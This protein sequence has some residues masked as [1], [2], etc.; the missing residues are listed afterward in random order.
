MNR[1]PF[2]HC[3]RIV[4]LS[5]TAAFSQISVTFPTNR[6]V[7]QR[8]NNNEATL[9]IGGYM[10]ESFS[11]IEARVVPLVAGEGQPSPV[12]GGWSTLQTAP[13]GGNFYGSITVKGGWYRLEVQGIRSGQSPKLA[14]V[15]R[16]GVGEVFLVAG[17]SNATGGDGRPNGPGA[18]HDQVNSV[19]FQNYVLSRNPQTLPYS[20]I[21]LPC[22]EFV[23]LDAEVKTAPFGNYAWCWGAF[24]D[25]I[26]EKLKVPV[27]IFNAGWSSTEIKNW[28]ETTNPTSNTFSAY[29][30]PFPQGLPFG[31]LRIALNNYIAQLGIRAILWHQGESDNF[32]NKSQADYASQLQEVINQ[33]RVVSGKTNLAWIVA[34][35]SRYYDPNY[36]NGT[37]RVWQNVIAAQNQVIDADA[38]V[39]PG[40]ET[41]GYYQS[42][43]REDGIHFTGTGLTSLAA[44][45]TDK[46]DPS[47]LSQS[48]PYAA[49]PPPHITT[50]QPSGSTDIV[51]TASARASDYTYQWIKSDNCTDFF[52][53]NESTWTVGGGTYRLKSIDSKKNT[54]LS[55]KLYVSGTALPLPVT[56]LSLAVRAENNRP[57]L[58]WSTAS[59]T[60]SSHFDIE[61]SSDARSF[62]KIATINAAGNSRAINEYRYTDEIT[63]AGSFYYRLKQVD[64][65][66]KFEYSRIVN[67]VL[68]GEEAVRIYPNPVAD[69]LNIE[70]VTTLSPIEITTL[71]GK[72]VHASK[73]V[74]NSVQIKVSDLPQGLYF[75]TVNG[76]KYKILKS[77]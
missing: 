28:Y 26:Y 4:L 33:S 67:I 46:I 71:E 51:L 14:S 2:S 70:S 60:G 8:D 11:R 10:T 54:V 72:Q 65:D 69:I 49:I 36:N 13:P 73:P 7:F 61:K 9:N 74:G 42:P 40:P 31:H 63:L 50:T 56:W 41:D 23:H 39:Y 53:L 1:F 55:P 59:E 57:S 25:K 5:S 6:A 19:D 34:R 24:G 43:Y 32:V 45:W 38:H 3:L 47:F 12:G 17:Q 37:I 64:F 75:V 44:F 66:G 77:F 18:I 35:V 62:R 30:Y 21:N 27:M 20:E 16:V 76:K 68:S 58:S 29:G 52:N 22:P 48:V 15:D